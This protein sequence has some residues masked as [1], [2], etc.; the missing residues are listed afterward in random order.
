MEKFIVENF[1]GRI[2]KYL[3]DVTE[4]SRAEIKRLIDSEVVFYNGVIVSKAGISVKSGDIIDV[5]FVKKQTF[6]LE[7]ENIPLDIVYE[8]EDIIVLN[9]QRN[10]VVHP[11]GGSET[12][13][14]VNALL[15][16]FGKH[17]STGSDVL[18]PG[19]VHRLDK[20]TSGLMMVAK[21]DVAHESLSKQLKDRTIL[22]KYCA[23]V[24]GILEF[25]N[26]TIDAPL[27]I[28]P[29]NRKLRAVTNINSKDARTNF[30]VLHR[31]ENMT[32][33]ECKLD[34]GRTHQ[35]RAH[36]LYIK[37]PI[38]GDP[39]YFVSKSQAGEGQMLHAF[40]L[41]FT[42]PTSGKYMEFESKLPDYFEKEL[43]SYDCDFKL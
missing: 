11:A 5:N 43:H 19:I 31:L 22:R 3:V 24:H 8:D 27:G 23:L 29:N 4:Y 7:P 34:T 41:G 17:L 30:K 1:K 20:D 32:I 37:H 15:F 14:L 26:G 18:R 25:D 39:K 2:D 36:F 10:L 13:T 21:N 38:V 16:H 40:K 6:S 28:D 33:V 12:G 35:I 9:K 42:H